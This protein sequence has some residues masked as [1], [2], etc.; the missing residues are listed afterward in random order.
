MILSPKYHKQFKAYQFTIVFENGVYRVKKS[1]RFIIADL[2][3]KEL[4]FNGDPACWP[5][6]EFL[7]FHNKEFKYRCEMAVAE[8]EDVELEDCDQPPMHDYEALGELQRK[9]IKDLTS[10]PPD[11]DPEID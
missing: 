2:D 6:P 9:W 10:D 7:A 8:S 3:E 5:A 11:S 4:K 1:D